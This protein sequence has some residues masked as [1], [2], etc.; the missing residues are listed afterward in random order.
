M[1]SL[2]RTSLDYSG[3]KNRKLRILSKIFRTPCVTACTDAIP[4]IYLRFLEFLASVIFNFNNVYSIFLYLCVT[5][6]LF[7]I[8]VCVWHFAPSIY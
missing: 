1:Y 8:C 4:L 6:M 3:K 7:S 2:K 5:M